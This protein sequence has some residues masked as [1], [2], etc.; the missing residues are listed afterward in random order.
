MT[1]VGKPCER[2]RN[3]SGPVSPKPRFLEDHL[4]TSPRGGHVSGAHHPRPLVMD[5][6]DGSLP[7]LP[8]PLSHSYDPI[9]LSLIYSGEKGQNPVVAV[10]LLR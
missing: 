2:K 10:R 8:L 4:W 3:G 1:R 9:F 5:T 7:Q 6:F